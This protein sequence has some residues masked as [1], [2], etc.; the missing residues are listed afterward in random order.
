MTVNFRLFLLTILIETFHRVEAMELSTYLSLLS[1]FIAKRLF[2]QEGTSSCQTPLLINAKTITTSHTNQLGMDLNSWCPTN[3][4]HQ[5]SLHVL[6]SN[7]TFLTAVEMKSVSNDFEYRLEYTREN[8]IDMN[9]V[10][11]V[12]RSLSNQH[13]RLVLDPPMI[14]RHVRLII[15]QMKTNTCVKFELFGCIFTDGVVSY[16]MLQGSNQLEDDTY[17]GNY[18]DKQHYLTGKN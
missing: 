1:L 14:A 5:P 4:D 11:R 2:S 13:E 18:D 9:T 8:Q 17:D 3:S 15:K 6:L 7:L 12:Y 16:N 10:W